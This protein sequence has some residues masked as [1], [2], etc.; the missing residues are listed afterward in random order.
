MQYIVHIQFY[1]TIGKSAYII[2]HHLM[3]YEN[4]FKNWQMTM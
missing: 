4:L 3:A 2:I 1:F